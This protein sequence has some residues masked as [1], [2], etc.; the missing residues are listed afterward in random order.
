MLS[1]RD[2]HFQYPSSD[3][4]IAVKNLDVRVGEPLAILGPSGGGKTT[5]LRLITGLLT[6]DQGAV[7]CDDTCLLELDAPSRRRFRLENMGLVFQDFALLDYLTVAE[8]ILLPA[9]F[10]NQTEVP[11]E[12]ARALAER[13]EIALHW[14]RKT[15]R[16]SQGEKQ[17]VA[18]VRALVHRPKFVFADEPTASLDARRRGLVMDLLLDYTREN[19]ACLVV[20][21]HDPE[22]MPLFPQQLRVE[23]LVTV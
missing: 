22:L 17:R 10:Q 3:F 7:I 8:N 20:V 19:Q 16:L 18:L 4:Q 13:L 5:L 12:H 1:L 21:T 23:E 11:W 6:P 9:Q 2:I 14:N 15:S